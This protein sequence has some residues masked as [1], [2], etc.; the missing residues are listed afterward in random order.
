MID[1]RS[2]D[3]HTQHIILEVYKALGLNPLGWYRRLLD[4]LFRFPA[5]R[6][7]R[8]AMAFDRQVAQ[9]GFTHAACWTLPNFVKGVDFIGLDTIP[10]EGPLLVV[11][12]HPGTVDG[13]C[14]A[15]GLARDDLRIVA[16][17]MPFLRGLQASARHFIYSSL[18]TYVRMMVVRSGIKHLRAGGALLIFPSGHLDPDPKILPGADQSLNEWSPSIELILRKVP[19][20]QILVTV[21]SGVLSRRNL[22]S[23]FTKFRKTLR[24]R[25]RIAEFI[26]VA[27]QMV[28]GIREDVVPRVSFAPPLDVP[29]LARQATEANLLPVLIGHAQELLSVHETSNARI[30]ERRL[31]FAKTL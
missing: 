28:L 16:S 10:K 23:P 4:P 12:N 11:S 25:Q 7:C 21:V 13:L 14:I 30:L 20:V 24:D 19:Q 1:N 15:A 26:Q 5:S 22:N 3:Q 9:N 18:D 6:F 17:G 2:L 27:R 29:E 31:N 8:I